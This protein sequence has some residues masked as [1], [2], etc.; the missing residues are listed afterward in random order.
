MS[1]PLSHDMPFVLSFGYT[2][3]AIYL[4]DTLWYCTANKPVIIPGQTMS[5]QIATYNVNGIA[6][7]TKRR[8]VFE[9][10]NTV[11]AK[12]ILIQETHSKVVTEHRWQREWTRG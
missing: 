6:D 4:S 12:I 1:S 3:L 8:A 10:L 9:Y 11:Q 5:L 7:P 2:Y